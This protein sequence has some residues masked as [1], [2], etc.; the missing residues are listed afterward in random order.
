MWFVVSMVLAVWLVAAGYVAVIF[1]A[2]A[3]SLPRGYRIL[4][5]VPLVRVDIAVNQDLVTIAIIALILLT[6]LGVVFI[7]WVGVD[8]KP[9]QTGRKGR[10]GTANPYV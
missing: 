8:S 7:V 9:E 6:I 3:F 2:L 1:S 10:P 4:Y 5:Q